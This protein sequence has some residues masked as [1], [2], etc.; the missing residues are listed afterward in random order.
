MK[1]TRVFASTCLLVSSVA[2]IT[3]ANISVGEEPGI[4]R[5]SSLGPQESGSG[6]MPNPIPDSMGSAGGPGIT[7][8]DPVTSGPYPAPDNYAPYFERSLG[9]TEA[10]QAPI[11]QTKQPFGP[12]LSFDSTFGSGLG[13]EEGSH[14]LNARLPYHVLPNTTVM[15]ADLAAAVTNDGRPVY[16]YGLVYRNYDSARNR[17]FGWNVFGD[18]DE[19]LGNTEWYRM[20]AGF[21]SLGK[22]IDWRANGYFMMGDDSL[23]LN[24]SLQGNLA[25]GGNNVFLMRNQTRENAY[26][27]FDI[28]TGGPLPILGSYGLNMYAGGYYLTNG[29]GFDTVGFQ[30]RWQALV[31]ESLSVNTYLTTDD[32]F[33]TNS[34]VNVAYSIP[35]YKGKRILRPSSVQD[36]LQDP[37]MRN[38]RVHTHIDQVVKPEA[39]VNAKTGNVYNFLYVDPN[40]SSSG[41]GTFESPFRTLEQAQAANNALV[42]MIRVTPNADDSGTNLTVNGG[43]HLFDCQILISDTK[44]FTLFSSGTQDFVIPGNPTT[45]DLGPLISNPT[46]VAGGSVVHLANQNQVIGMRIDAANAAGTIFGNGV[47]NAVPIVDT[48]LVMNTFTNYSVGANLQDV[49]GRVVVDMNTFA[50]TAGSTPATT[51]V[52]GLNL[53]TAPGTTTSLLVRSNIASNNASTG[54]SIIA[55][56]GSTINAD[57]PA[58]VLPT[59]IVDN[60]TSNNG[61]AIASTGTG[62]RTEAMAGSTFNAVVDGNISTNNIGD[63]FS[64]TSDAATYN[65]ASLSG[66]TFSNNQQNGAFLHYLNGGIFRSVS[67]DLN[68]DGVLDA[69]E[70]LNGNGRLDFGIV[71]NSMSNNLIAGLCIF[72]E[73]NSTGAFDIGGPQ[74]TLGNSFIGNIGAGVAVDLKDSATAQIDT[75]NNLISSTTVAN[76]APTLTFVLDFVEAGQTIVDPFGG[77]TFTPFDVG[78]FG[79]NAGDFDL[80]TNAILD[81]VRQHYYGIPTTGNDSR[82]PI[83]D[84]QQLDLNF[85]IGDLGIA[86]TIGATEFYTT[87]I[88]TAPTAPALGVA[89]ASAVRDANGN[90]PLP[91]VTQ[92]GHVASVYSNA[93]NSIG[94]LTPADIVIP[95]EPEGIHYDIAQGDGTQTLQDALVSGN[96]TFTRNALAGTISHEIAHTLSL[97]HMNV[98]GAITPTGAPPIMGTGAI[99]L[100]NQARILPREFG[101]TGQDQEQGNATVNH[102][103][104]LVGAVGTRDAA[105]AGVSGHGVRISATDN[106]VL[107][108]ST[109]INNT[110][111][112]NS[113]DGLAIVMNDNSVA[114]SVTIQGNTIT[115]NAGRG[116]DLQANG[117][118][119]FIDA[120][121]TIGGSGIN[122]L[123]GSTF[124]QGNTI[125]QNQGDGIRALASNGGVIHGNAI[126]NLIQRNAGNGIAL[127][128]DN[129][130]EVDFGTT[131]SNRVIRANSITGNGGSGIALTSNVS[132]SST[133]LMNASVYGNTISGNVGGGI[134][135]N[136]NG[137][138]NTPPALPVVVENNVL[139]LN[140][141]GVATA[142]ANTFDGNGDAGIAVQVTGNGK[143]LVDIRNAS[144][145]NTTNGAD[146]I[147]NGDGINLRR[148]DT[149]YLRATIDNVTVTGNAGDGLDVDAQGSPKDDPNQPM[150]GSPNEVTVTNSTFS[151]NGENGARFRTR[152]DTNLVGDMTNVVLNNNGLNGILVQTSENSS[153]GDPTDGLP[154]GRRSKFDGIQANNNGVDGLQILASGSSR[155][156]VEV[157]ST[158]APGSS[159]A[160]AALNTNGNSG[161]SNNGRDG[162]HIE[163]TGGT[164]DIL[165]T[166]STGQTIISGNGT[167]AGG[168]GIRWDATGSSDGSVRITNTLITNNIAGATE[169]TNG[170]GVVNED[171]NGN[172]ILDLLEDVNGNGVLDVAE[173]VNNNGDID[174]ADGDGIQFNVRSDVFGVPTPTL[175]VGGIG[176]GNVIQSNGDNGIEI[177]AEG[178]ALFGQP[179]PIISVVENTIGGTVD[180]IPAGNA[181]SGL[182]LNIQGATDALVP[183]DIDAS[184]PP[185]GGADGDLIGA[186]GTNQDGVFELG[187]VVQLN[188]DGNTISNNNRRGVNLLITGAA[189]NRDREFAALFDP[190]LITLN[191][192]IVVSNGEEGIYFRGDAEMNQSRYTYLANFP[193]PDP[194]FNPANQRPQNFFFYTPTQ[195]EF[196]NRNIGSVNGN[197]T[198]LPTAPDGASGYLNLRTVQNTLL[199][200]TN[201]TIQNNGVNTVTGE[202]M[203]LR[204]GTGSYLAADIQNN[205]YGGNLDADVRTDSFLSFGNTFDS[206]ENTG[207]GT[208]DV[209]FWDD[210]AQ[211]DMRFQNNTGDQINVSSF[212]ATYSNADGLKALALGGLGVLDR[213]AGLFQVENGANLDDPNNSFI[214]FGLTQPIN[215]SFNAGGY[216]IRAAAD[217]L[218]PNIGFAPFLP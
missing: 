13:F 119:A 28:E 180:G 68:G 179:R 181:G 113:R 138:N 35:N 116:V 12:I 190:T 85:V 21:E 95:D 207:D 69:G 121:S 18:Y 152:G 86:P 91:F 94:G 82:S 149:S 108:P 212:G 122:T 15:M 80:V 112:N 178:S 160:H 192:N 100:S 188:V 53:T 32:T 165:I 61:D 182:K 20:T 189:G 166:S 30:A 127:M 93:I 204:V 164:S 89:F 55:K 129:G 143:A 191:N 114:Q 62:I 186:N 170:D 133:G 88:G 209:I 172:G 199:T 37:V 117:A 6:S 175:V 218:F 177:N 31:T 187:P 185:A 39:V 92:G 147:L 210:T 25:L 206:L 59:G 159:A 142:D 10:V 107:Q 65:L 34:W 78:S 73:D 42:D 203:Y 67:E 161:Y 215:G 198:F 201:N 17:I 200:V 216:N 106:A 135:A 83:P 195:A 139:N 194:P 72:G 173:D 109:F 205:T 111:T 183:A 87:V 104:Q 196:I 156:L 169:D 151:N 144:I 60:T 46:M 99:D 79:F 41:L 43:L 27:G 208:F 3:A 103:Q 167:T 64:A 33:G 50:G 140:V 150:S 23:L 1:T 105:S 98:A 29:D 2:L 214:N 76:T 174:V 115:G 217:A 146:P 44:D 90:G 19:G 128:I 4:V 184:V 130:G 63:G 123:G 45:T 75:L 193:F 14:R 148:A 131:A 154:P 16:N 47:S 54:L 66:N 102:V 125:S 101:Y 9:A 120:D 163:T 153:F 5:L 56:P 132:A 74:T 8:G 141:G 158:R 81:T 24:D 168:N 110:I 58:G 26:S 84:G 40:A 97:S 211:L 137:P 51:S 213:D 22:Y 11:Y 38:N 70:D 52:D 96:L 202:G 134:N 77:G 155:A 118:G 162:I 126:N 136:L 157:T 176:E 145:T 49:S 48:S 36:R 57:N 7:Y 71:S 197:T 124:S 171:L